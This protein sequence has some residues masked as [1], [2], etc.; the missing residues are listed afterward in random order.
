MN[1][2]IVCGGRIEDYSYYTRYFDEADIVICADSGARHLRAFGKNPDVLIGDFDSI[3]QSDY[4]YFK[5]QGAEIL[6]FPV[7]KDMTDSELALNIAIDRGCKSIV[8]I[9][10]TGTRYDHSLSNILMLKKIIEVGLVG[11]IV[12]EHNEITL[13]N[14]MITIP[15]DI[16]GSIRKV[17]LLPVSQKVVGVTSKGLYYALDNTTLELGSSIGIS[18]EFTED[19]AIISIERGELLVIVARD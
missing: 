10:S 18:N 5:A 11:K 6:K 12:D 2:L 13:I 9:G 16:N 8:F 15:R 1:A 3:S 7:E 14:D 17:S 4:D 19:Y